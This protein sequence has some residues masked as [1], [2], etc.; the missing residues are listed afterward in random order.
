MLNG[1]KLTSNISVKGQMLTFTPLGS[2]FTHLLVQIR[3]CGLVAGTPGRPL[4]LCSRWC[5]GSIC[6]WWDSGRTRVWWLWA[7]V[8]QGRPRPARRLPWN[9]SN[10]LAQQETAS[11]VSPSLSGPPCTSVRPDLWTDL[12]R[13]SETHSVDSLNTEQSHFF[14]DYFTALNYRQH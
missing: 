3:E 12:L 4:P 1:V 13:S 14:T 5:G 6:L 11:P 2:V 10:K 8:A 7:A 9:F